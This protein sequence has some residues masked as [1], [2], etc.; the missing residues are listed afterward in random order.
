LLNYLCAA[1][2]AS[3]PALLACLQKCGTTSLAAY[4]RCHPGVS[5]I[6]SM[7]G[8]EAF[9][10]ESHFF[11]GMLGRGTTHSATLYRSFFPTA[12]TR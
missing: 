3:L 1:L 10:K 4:L 6:S 8:H 7:P 5:G 9:S 11:G 12:M 2:L